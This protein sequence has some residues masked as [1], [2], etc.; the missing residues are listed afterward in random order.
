MPYWR[1]AFAGKRASSFDSAVA[2]L[3]LSFRFMYAYVVN[4]IYFCLF[5]D[6][7]D[8]GTVQRKTPRR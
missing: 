4:S 3:S 6:H 5:P 7:F 2:P 1:A 8:S